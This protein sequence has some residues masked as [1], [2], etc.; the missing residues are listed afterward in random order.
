[1]LH[2]A[3]VVAVSATQGVALVF[4]SSP[5]IVL[6]LKPPSAAAALSLPSSPS[7][8][9]A[10]SQW[11]CPVCDFARNPPSA[12]VCS[13]C[14]VKRQ[15]LP[16]AA[17]P[18][19]LPITS[20]FEK[21]CPVCTFINHKDIIFCEAC[22][23]RFPEVPATASSSSPELSTKT[24]EDVTFAKLSF[25]GGGINEFYK[26]LKSALAAK[27][28]TKDESPK[29]FAGLNEISG[30]LNV[31]GGICEF[32]LFFLKQFLRETKFLNK[33]IY[34]MKP[35][36]ILKNAD[37]STSKLD[38]TLSSSFQDLDALMSKAS[39]MVMAATGG[40]LSGVSTALDNPELVAFRSFLVDLGIPSPVTKEM[41]GDAFTEEIA[42]EL[43]T[44]LSNLLDTA[45]DGDGEQQGE[46]A[47]R[48]RRP[49]M[50]ALTELYCVF[51]RA[52]G[53]AALVSPRDLLA[54]VQQLARL[55]LPFRVRT[56]GSSSS[57][58]S[59]SS[60]A[61]RGL[62]V[63]VPAAAALGDD[64]AIAARVR[65]CCAAAAAARAARRAADAPPSWTWGP[66]IGP[67]DVAAS[68]SVSGAL[69]K[70]LLLIA[71]KQGVVC[72]DD[73]VEGLR[74]YE[75]IFAEPTK[76]AAAKVPA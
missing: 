36:G 5:K 43:A 30:A 38:Q 33:C 62:S 11:A 65:A 40:S 20:A 23:S 25:R 24:S 14:G 66:G 7:M 49:K 1:M 63:V 52:R 8:P 48:R 76:P 21:A 50:I 51:N 22:H 18:V 37:E 53:A 67:A 34:R 74:F 31:G 12:D 56:F 73:S 57:S 54:S 55:G 4:K 41:A 9:L 16:V 27:E 75:N 42:R 3:D 59:S 64:A 2:L 46:E 19:L 45:N 15:V 28:W 10:A 70:E 61:A 32:V 39:E 58:S 47:G 60:D 44:L 69:A 6:S 13:E 29:P 35:A 72:R 17:P 68:E 71:E 26:V